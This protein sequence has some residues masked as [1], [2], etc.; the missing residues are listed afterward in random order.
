M[1]EDTKRILV[2]VVVGSDV[3]VDVDADIGPR[4]VL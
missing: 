3:E 4:T 2:K 1:D